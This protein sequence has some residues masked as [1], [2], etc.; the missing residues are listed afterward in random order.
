MEKFEKVRAEYD[1]CRVELN[2]DYKP[3]DVITV[4]VKVKHLRSEVAQERELDKHFHR[5]P[6]VTGGCPAP[7]A[8]KLEFEVED[9]CI[10]IESMVFENTPDVEMVTVPPFPEKACMPKP[11][12]NDYTLNLKEEDL[13]AAISKCKDKVKPKEDKIAFI[14]LCNILATK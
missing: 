7:C 14:S 9:L 5:I 10:L 13:A 1:I 11:L 2:V 8:E 6:A 12:Q 4:D 3:D